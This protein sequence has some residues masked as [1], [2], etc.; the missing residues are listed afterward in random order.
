[1]IKVARPHPLPDDW[2]VAGD[3]VSRDGTDEHIVIETFGEGEFAPIQIHVECI[4]EP[5]GYPNE[6]GSVGE[7]WT[8]LGEREWNLSR[9]YQ[10]IRRPT[11]TLSRLTA[12]LGSKHT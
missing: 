9:R 7:P 11:G 1:M 2:F 6:D 8:R 12:A 10:L 5:L 3:I 4:K